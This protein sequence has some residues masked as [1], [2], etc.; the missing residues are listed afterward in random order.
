MKAVRFEI[1]SNFGFFQWEKTKGDNRITNIFISKT[2]ILGILGAIVGLD[3]YGQTTFKEKKGILSE[4]SFYKV[5]NGLNVSILPNTRPELFED[6]LI[7]RHMDH[8]NKKGSLMVKI[9][10]LIKPSY[11]IVVTQGSAEDVV[12]E[13][14]QEY[15]EKGIAEFIPYMGK[16]QYPLEIKNVK[17]IDLESVEQTEKTKIHSIYKQKSIVEEPKIRER[18]LVEEDYHYTET[19]RSFAGDQITFLNEKHVWSSFDVKL[20]EEVFKTDEEEYIVFL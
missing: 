19:L 11:T 7:H 17:S 10:G 18:K 6:H 8:I 13:K 12:F 1:S 20:D 15:L 9:T 16:N 2:E 5:L 3:G 14:I 4:N